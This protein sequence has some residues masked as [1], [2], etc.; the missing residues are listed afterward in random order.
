MPVGWGRQPLKIKE[1]AEEFR[2]VIYRDKNV[3]NE[4][5]LLVPQQG[6]YY[7]RSTKKWDPFKHDI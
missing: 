6:K 5:A 1:S 3:W 2:A 7:E 4:Q